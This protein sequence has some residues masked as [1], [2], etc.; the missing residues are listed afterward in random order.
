MKSFPC[1]IIIGLLKMYSTNCRIIWTSW[2]FGISFVWMRNEVF[3]EYEMCL[4]HT[5][6]IILRTRTKSGICIGGTSK[7][8]R[9]LSSSSFWGVMILCI[10]LPSAGLPSM[11]VRHQYPTPSNLTRKTHVYAIWPRMGLLLHP[12]VHILPKLA[13]LWKWRR[14]QLILLS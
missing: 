8:S 10:N 12:G 2:T 14:V 7:G 9:K 11:T 3:V 6:R 4:T 5:S 1:L 13:S